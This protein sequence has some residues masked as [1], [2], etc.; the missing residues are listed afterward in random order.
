MEVLVAPSTLLEPLLSADVVVT[1]GGPTLLEAMACGR[2][3][4]VLVLAENQR[5]QAELAVHEGAA[6]LVDPPEDDAVADAV[7]ELAGDPERRAQ[8]A[9]AARQLV[10]GQGARR[11]AVEVAAL[12]EEEW[13]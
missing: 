2:P 4:I 12:L 8:L 10:N 9:I 6:V 11:V 1:A 5:T 7:A 3:T 13:A